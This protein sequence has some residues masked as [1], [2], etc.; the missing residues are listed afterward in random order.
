VA[1]LTGHVLK[2]PGILLE[3]HRNREPAPPGANRPITID[4]RLGEVE[5]ILN[6]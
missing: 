1:I 2:D 4:A 3:Y 5:R 6:S